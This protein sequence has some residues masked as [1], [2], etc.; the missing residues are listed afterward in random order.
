MAKEMIRLT[1]TLCTDDDKKLYAQAVKQKYGPIQIFR[2]GLKI[3]NES[4]RRS[5]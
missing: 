4:E 3:I 1:L 2:L 5:K